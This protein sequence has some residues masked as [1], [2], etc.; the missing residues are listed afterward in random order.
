MVAALLAAC[1]RAASEARRCLDARIVQ[2]YEL[3]ATDVITSMRG[4]SLKKQVVMKFGLPAIPSRRHPLTGACV[5]TAICL[6]A[7]IK[8]AAQTSA[9]SPATGPWTGWARCQIAVQ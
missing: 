9:A 5:I 3:S 7:I 4:F 2:L 8:I 1:S 6:A